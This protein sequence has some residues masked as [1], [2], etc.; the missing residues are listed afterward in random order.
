MVLSVFKD[1]QPR[2]EKYL[3]MAN[4]I[5]DKNICSI[6]T[7]LFVSAS[8]KLKHGIKSSMNIPESQEV[9]FSKPDNGLNTWVNKN[10]EL[11]NCAFTREFDSKTDYVVANVS[12]LQSTWASFS[13][14]GP[15]MKI[16]NSFTYTQ[17]VKYEARLLELP[18]RSGLKLVIVVPNE[19]DVLQNL[20]NILKD[21]GLDAAVR[22]IQPLFTTKCELNAP[23]ISINSRIENSEEINRFAK[24]NIVQYGALIVNKMGANVT[25][26]TCLT[27]PSNMI[28]AQ[29][30]RSCN[31]QPFYVGIVYEDTPLFIGRFTK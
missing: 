16:Y 23:N 1:G 28:P 2:V 31:N 15:I 11:R 21:Q 6:K 8:Y 14:S 7:K 9:D 25:V 5:K 19:V 3:Q 22:S 12:S 24:S 18:L 26:L 30:E 20:F 27:V 4:H 10:V 29:N 17:D 13:D